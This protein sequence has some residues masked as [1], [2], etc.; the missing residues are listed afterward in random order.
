[1]QWNYWINVSTIFSLLFAATE[2]WF[3]S[4]H[5]HSLLKQEDLPFIKSC[6][7]NQNADKKIIIK[8]DNYENSYI[9]TSCVILT[10]LLKLLIVI[11]LKL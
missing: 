7:S 9:F 4:L 8:V 2:V 1:M 5:W 11:Y 6:L 3:V 10:F